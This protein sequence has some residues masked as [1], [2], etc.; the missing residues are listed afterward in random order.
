MRLD[1]VEIKTTIAGDAT[2][3]A[4]R[5][6]ALP[7]GRPPWEI[8]FCED[9][10]DG[11]SAATP[12]LD[13]GV[14]L[15]ARAK[16]G[17]K[18]DTTVKLRPCRRSQLP[19]RWLEAEKDDDWELKV[20]ADWAGDRR[21]LA[22]SLTADRRNGLVA[23]VSRGERPVEDLFVAEQL[24]FLRESSTIG[25]NLATLT[26]LPAV[27]A[28]RWGSVDGTPAGLDLRA[29][30]WTV[31]DLDFLELSAVAPVDGAPAAQQLLAGF[32]ESLDVGAPP[33][34][35]TKTRQVLRSLVE[36]ELARGAAV[37]A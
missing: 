27:T 1:G 18:D 26:V 19:D 21:A 36:R 29:E 33:D 24:A 11:L 12:L 13:V 25:I 30:R 23:A 31:G 15:R 35:E 14:I 20:E 2:P 22:A 3:A 17:G 6:L 7:P 37:G 9:V 10:T 16:P 5:A 28:T 34:Q 8:F 32:V 4:I